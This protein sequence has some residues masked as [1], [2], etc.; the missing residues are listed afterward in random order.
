[1]SQKNSLESADGEFSLLMPKDLERRK[2]SDFSDLRW[3]S[4]LSWSWMAS[5]KM[6]KEN[7]RGFVVMIRRRRLSERWTTPEEERDWMDWS[8]ETRSASALA[9]AAT[10]R[11]VDSE[12][13]VVVSNRKRVGVDLGKGQT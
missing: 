2:N 1:M 8:S 9:A 12:R 7:D 10:K 11:V 6:I 13:S 5:K 4:D 3:S